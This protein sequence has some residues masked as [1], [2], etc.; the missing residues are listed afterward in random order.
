MEL[1]DT[2][3]SKSGAL[4]SV[5]VQVPPRPPKFMEIVRYFQAH[6]EK[7]VPTLMILG[8]IVSSVFYF[9]KGD[10]RHG[11]YWIAGAV[12]TTTVTY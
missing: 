7:F 3:D 1:A 5:R 2:P 10:I 12:L 9:A 8:S 6:P 11:L 4:K